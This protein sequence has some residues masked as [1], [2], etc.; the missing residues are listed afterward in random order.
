MTL[1]SF[2]C[3]CQEQQLNRSL[4]SSRLHI[5]PQCQTCQ[6][7]VHWVYLWGCNSRMLADFLQVCNTSS[8][9]IHNLWEDIDP[10]PLRWLSNIM[11][12]GTFGLFQMSF[13]DLPKDNSFVWNCHSSGRCPSKTEI[14]AQIICFY[15]WYCGPQWCEC[16]F[17]WMF[18]WL[19]ILG[20]GSFPWCALSYF[21][22]LLPVSFNQ[23][24]Q[25]ACT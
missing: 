12:G 19:Q 10:P 15:N 13:R 5:F 3:W 4:N 2:C 6:A 18:C 21:S 1:N 9:H 20:G 8:P 22:E 25:L 16:T 11:H 23:E 24:Q 7:K 14:T 17:W